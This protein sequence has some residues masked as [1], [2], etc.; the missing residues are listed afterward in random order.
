MNPSIN[1]NLEKRFIKL[2][3]WMDVKEEV[4][5]DID[6]RDFDLR[7]RKKQGENGEEIKWKKKR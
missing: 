6:G 2:Q 7:K 1:R 3:E 5:K 4:F